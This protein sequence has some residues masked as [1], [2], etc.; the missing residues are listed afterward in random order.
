MHTGKL[1]LGGRDWFQHQAA[2]L[3]EVHGD[4]VEHV[5]ALRPLGVARRGDV[6][7]ETR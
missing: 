5:G 7:F 2:A 3:L 6:F 1:L 4:H